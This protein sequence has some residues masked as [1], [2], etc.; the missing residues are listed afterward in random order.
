MLVV[1][2]PYRSRGIG[3][4]LNLRHLPIKKIIICGIYDFQSDL[5]TAINFATEL[6]ILGTPLYY[7][8]LCYIVALK[9]F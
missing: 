2:K 7:D 9:T 6:L 3:N 8:K 4:F 5:I 1:I